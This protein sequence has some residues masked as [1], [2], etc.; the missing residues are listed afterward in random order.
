MIPEE[1]KAPKEYEKT[2]AFTDLIDFKKGL[3]KAPHSSWVKSRDLSGS[4]KSKY[5]P[6]YIQ[7]ALADKFFRECNVISENYMVV[8]NEIVCTVKM[9]ALPDYPDSEHL[10]FTGTGAKPIQADAGSTP[11]KFP[12]GKK[13]NA[14]EY[15]APA[16]RSAAIS[17]AYT[18]FANIFGRNLNR[19]AVN[20]FSIGKKE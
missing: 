10:H 11:S 6:L 14:L 5:V 12:L 8:V 3:E 18:S 4:K 9:S 1:K 17:N 13:T 2:Y 15:N 20:N 7:E 16:A 19:D